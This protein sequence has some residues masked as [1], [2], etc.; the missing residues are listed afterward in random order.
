MLARP[1]AKVATAVRLRVRCDALRAARAA[2]TG[3]AAAALLAG[4]AGSPKPQ[5]QPLAPLTPQ[6]VVGKLWSQRIEGVKFPLAIATSGGAF[7]VAASDGS[8]LALDAAS[9]REVWRA[10]VG[11]KLSAGVGSD[12]RF[13][14]VVTTSNE[15][16]T[17]E[18]GRVKWRKVLGTRVVTAPLVAG[19]R[20][21]VLGVDRSVQAFDALDGH[22]IW[23]LQRPG[24]PLTLAQTGVLTAFDDTLI[25]GQGPRLAGVDPL[26]GSVR[27]EVA[28]GTPRG[29]NEI[30]RLADLVGPA[31]RVGQL[32]C[33]RSFQ[34]A[35]G[36]VD[37]ARGALA[38]SKNAGGTQGVAADSQYVFGADASDRLS[39]WKMASG[40]AAWSSDALKYRGL[41]APLSVGASVVFGDADGILHWLAR[42]SGAPQLRLATD[43][44]AIVAAPTV[45]G[46]T[47]LAVTRKGGL[48]AFRT[49]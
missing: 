32:F 18:Q 19:E 24:D 17:L 14:S 26:R 41:S 49:P 5:P 12:G 7:T 3:L 2:A 11:A 38:W 25:V 10:S 33:V 23:S 6:I 20:V 15:L 27:W 40:D 37:A 34:A 42:D 28:V 16:V 39:A 46:S 48:F 45:L 44:S 31:A 22:P 30:E 21:F 47:L 4:C 43:G 1:L 29:A 13:S 35:V 36:C 9:G 8:V